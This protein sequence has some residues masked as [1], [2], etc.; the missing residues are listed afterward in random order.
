MILL[1]YVMTLC[2]IVIENYLCIKEHRKGKNCMFYKINNMLNFNSTLK[3][4][5]T[6]TRPSSSKAA[7]CESPA[8]ICITRP[9]S[10]TNP[11]RVSEPSSEVVLPNAPS[12]L[13]PKVKTVPSFVKQTLC[14]PPAAIATISVRFGIAQ[15]RVFS[16]MF[17]PKPS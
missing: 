1:C 4:P 16:K 6:N 3:E 17:S 12:S 15:K 7:L 13:H 9:G 14:I 10:S 5:Q 11:G 2:T 8:V